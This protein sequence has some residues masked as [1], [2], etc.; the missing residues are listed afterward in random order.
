M[1]NL[2]NTQNNLSNLPN[3]VSGLK[4]QTFS[5]QQIRKKMKSKRKCMEFFLSLGK[6]D[7]I[8]YRLLPSSLLLLRLGV[9][10]DGLL[11]QEKGKCHILIS[12]P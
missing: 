6:F 8:I 12:A 3:Q 10:L 2:V 4:L 7:V 11:W 1:N 5:L 9:C